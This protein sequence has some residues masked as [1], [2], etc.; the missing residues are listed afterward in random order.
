MTKVESFKRELQSWLAS[1]HASLHA[2]ADEDFDCMR[3]SPKTIVAMDCVLQLEWRNSD[4]G[5]AQVFGETHAHWRTFLDLCEKGY[6]Q[7]GAL[8][9]ANRID[10]VRQLFAL[11]EPSF[12]QAWS[13]DMAA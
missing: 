13:N 5:L 2:W 8:T 6:L 4:G 11:L 3:S 7:I 10:E 9:H 12:K 1:R